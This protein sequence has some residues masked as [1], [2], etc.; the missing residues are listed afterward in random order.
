MSAGT[1]SQLSRARRTKRVERFT[2]DN[3]LLLAISPGSQIL[4]MRGD[5]FS[6]CR[7]G[8]I[9]CR[10]ARTSTLGTQHL[11]GNLHLSNHA[12]PQPRSP[13]HLVPVQSPCLRSTT[14]APVF[15]L[16]R[17]YADLCTAFAQR[18][19]LPNANHHACVFPRELTV[20][21]G[22]LAQGAVC[23][24]RM[25][26]MPPVASAPARP[27]HRRTLS[28]GVPHLPAMEDAVVQMTHVGMP[29]GWLV[30][31][32][33]WLRAHLQPAASLP[34][35]TTHATVDDAHLARRLPS[36][37]SAD[38]K[39]PRASWSAAH[40]LAAPRATLSVSLSSRAGAPPALS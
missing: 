13:R 33:L 8:V 38:L 37:E 29:S 14:H 31:L 26:V 23:V 18:R 27:P 28:R 24:G 16:S 25:L 9:I 36:A 5:I 12:A 2:P 32:D 6:R 3:R 7:R 19:P 22:V 30:M 11:P 35:P 20:R 1:S 40:R 34:L 4:T 21:I 17:L 15:K 10:V 39:R